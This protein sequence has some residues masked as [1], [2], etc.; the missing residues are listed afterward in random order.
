[1]SLLYIKILF[2]ILVL[3]AAAF[4]AFLETA[5]TSLRIFKIREFA[6]TTK[7]YKRLFETWENNPSRILISVLIASNFADVLCS[8]LVADITHDFLGASG[9]SFILEAVIATGLILIFGEIVPKSYAKAHCERLF[10]SCLWCLNLLYYIFHPIVTILLRCTNVIISQIRG[11]SLND[12]EEETV[13]EHEIKFLIDY[14][15]KKGL[16]EADKSIMLQNIFDLGQTLVKEILVPA[17]EMVLLDVHSTLEEAMES[18]SSSRFSRLPVYEGKED[19]IIGLIHQKDLFE[20]VYRKSDKKLSELV[21]PIL[22]EPET[23]KVN[24]LLNEFLKHHTHMAI[25]FDEYGEL[26][27]LVTLEDILEEIVG[28]DI[29]DEHEHEQQEIVPV[30]DGGWIVDA[31][32]GL[33]KL[34]EKFGISF[35]VNDSLTLGGFLAEHLQ[36]L[37]RKGERLLY[38]SYYFQVYRATPRRVYQ[39]FVVEKKEDSLSSEIQ[40]SS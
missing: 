12:A 7:R 26:V 21:K 5:F 32:I 29:L 15:D 18:F 27:G 35:D 2:F 24:Q 4:F 22:F 14:S 31:R 1:M 28:Q 20:V 19:N 11:A 8:I 39:V 25:I 33:S 40:P 38:K 3:C 13:S 16:I 30:A 23:K 36:R 34:E 6:T 37:P 17:N 10:G 9:F